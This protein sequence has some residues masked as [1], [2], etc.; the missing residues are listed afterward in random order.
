L[1]SPRPHPD[2]VGDPFVDGVLVP[3]HGESV[4]VSFID[5]ELAG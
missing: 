2:F 1:V 5:V 4:T 3:P